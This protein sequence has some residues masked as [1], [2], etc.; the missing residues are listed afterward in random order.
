MMQDTQ[1]HE[2]N[3]CSAWLLWHLYCRKWTE[4][5][6]RTCCLWCWAEA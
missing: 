1:A 4:E 2:A 6:G 5:W 3:S